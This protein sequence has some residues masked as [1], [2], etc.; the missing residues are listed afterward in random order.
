MVGGYYKKDTISIIQVES[1][2]FNLPPVL[3]L[4][5]W[6]GGG[7]MNLTTI[8]GVDPNRALRA[9]PVNSSA[10]CRWLDDGSD[11]EIVYFDWS[12]PATVE[13]IRFMDAA[14]GKL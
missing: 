13:R 4:R 14:F 1:T 3:V 10:G 8:E 7:D 11:L 6:G 9:M 12:H 2:R 5:G